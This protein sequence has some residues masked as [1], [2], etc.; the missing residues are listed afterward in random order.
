MFTPAMSASST[1]APSVIIVQALWTQVISPPFLN[2]FPFADEITTGLLD[3]E[4]IIFG[5][6]ARSEV[7]A[8]AASVAPIVVRTKSRRFMWAR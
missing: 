7:E 3:L 5:L 4:L 2:L 1:S 8:L 6:C